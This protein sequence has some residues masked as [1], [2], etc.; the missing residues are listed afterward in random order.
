MSVLIDLILDQS[1]ILCGK[2]E[3][4]TAGHG[5]RVGEGRLVLSPAWPLADTSA[6]SDFNVLAGTVIF[7]VLLQPDTPTPGS[8][9]LSSLRS[10]CGLPGSLSKNWS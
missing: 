8:S 7:G 10:F 4:G 3:W 9:A 5:G 2:V 6:V 1:A